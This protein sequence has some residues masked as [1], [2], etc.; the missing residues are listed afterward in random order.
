[1]WDDIEVKVTEQKISYL[2][3]KSNNCKALIYQIVLD[4]VLNLSLGDKQY[5]LHNEVYLFNT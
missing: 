3:S 5:E 1:M 2:K 4:S